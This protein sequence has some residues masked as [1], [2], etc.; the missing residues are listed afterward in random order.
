MLLETPEHEQNVKV[1][2][3]DR[4]YYM[5]RFWVS[6]IHTDYTNIHQ[7]LYFI[8]YNV[9]KTAIRVLTVRHD[10]KINLCITQRNKQAFGRTQSLK[11]SKTTMMPC[12]IIVVVLAVRSSHKC[13]FTVVFGVN[14][15]AKLRSFSS[16]CLCLLELYLNE[17]RPSVRIFRALTTDALI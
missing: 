9:M 10:A 4:Y 13:V 15:K 7:M 6:L 11:G 12:F 3:S 2:S 17:G 5:S 8:I 16:F 1:I 14:N